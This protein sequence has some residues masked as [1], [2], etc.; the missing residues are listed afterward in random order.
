MEQ[1]VVESVA[2]EPLE[3][4]S[5][6]APSPRHAPEAV[7]TAQLDT[8]RGGDFARARAFASPANV[9]SRGPIELFEKARTISH[10]SPYDR[11]RVVNAVS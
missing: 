7:V 10:W 8:L 4:S 2:G 1:W 9:A 5:P 11:V 3:E 6:E